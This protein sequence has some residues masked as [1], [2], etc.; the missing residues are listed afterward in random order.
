MQGL[1]SV[2][3]LPGEGGDDEEVLGEGTGLEGEPGQ[4]EEQEGGSGDR[5]QD[6]SEGQ[7]AGLDGD[8]HQR[9]QNS[10]DHEG[11]AQ[12]RGEQKRP[13]HQGQQQLQ[14]GN[15]E[16]RVDDGDDD[17]Q[18]EHQSGHLLEQEEGGQR[19]G[20]QGADSPLH[21]QLLQYAQEDTQDKELDSETEPH[22]PNSKP[23]GA[24]GTLPDTYH[25]DAEALT[26]VDRCASG[27]LDLNAASMGAA[28]L[29]SLPDQWEGLNG[30]GDN[31]ALQLRDMPPLDALTTKTP[32]LLATGAN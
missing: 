20:Q 2:G 32:K 5:P 14:H 25:Q 26:T 8:V 17:G 16:E 24:V 3:L 7:Q 27:S 1:P 6:G 12:S 22:D 19:A 4:Q 15:E 23:Q 9:D 11:Q 29:G 30:D 13:H 21:Q 10:V 28:G 18:E 31:C